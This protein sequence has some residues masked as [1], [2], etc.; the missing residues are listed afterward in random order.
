MNI[1]AL[2]WMEIVKRPMFNILI[3]LLASFGGN[4]GIAI[5]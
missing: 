5:I 2:L 3:V 4:L 1:F